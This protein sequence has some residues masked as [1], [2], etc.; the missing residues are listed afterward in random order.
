MANLLSTNVSGRLY[1]SGHNDTNTAMAAFRFYDGSTFRGGLGLDDWAHGG[2]AANI[3]M[4][5]NG[6]NNFFISTSGVKR[7]QFNSGAAIFRTYSP[8]TAYSIRIVGGDTIG[9]YYNESATTLYVNWNGGTTRFGTG[10]IRSAGDITADTNIWAANGNGRIA[11]GGNLHIDSYNGQDIYLNY[12]TNQPIR[13]YGATHVNGIAYLNGYTKISYDWGGGQYGAE[14]LTIRGTHPSIALR[15]TNANF[16]WLLHTDASGNF[17]WYTGSELDDN[18]WTNRFTF[19]IDNNFYVDY[20]HVYVSGG[21]SVNWN[22]AYGWGNHASAGYQSAST[23]I[24]TSNIGSQSVSY[25]S[26]ASD[27]KTLDG[28]GSSRFLYTTTD[29]F[30]GDWNTLTDG[31]QEIRLVEV[32]NITGGAHSN[33]PTGLYAYGSVLGWQLNNST[34]KLYNSHTGDLAFQTG[35]NNDGY[36]GWRTII[37]SANIG[38]QSVNYAASAGAVAWGNITSVPSSFTPSSHTHDDRYYT[39]SEVNT[40]LAGKL[41]TSGKAADAETVDGIDSSRIVYGQNERRTTRV[42]GDGIVSRSQ[43]SGFYYGYDPDGGPYREWWN[44]LTVAGASWTSNDNY[45]FKLAHDFHSDSFYVS[46]MANGAQYGWRQVI[47]SGNIGSQS[48]SNADTVDGYHAS[49]FPYRLNNSHYQTNN[50]IQFNAEYG[51]YWPNNYDTHLHANHLSSYTQLAIRG[52]KNSYGGIYDQYSGVNGFMYDS[53]GNGGVY[54][55]GTGRWYLYHHVGN[56]CM[57]VGTSTTSGSYRLYVAGGIYATGD[58]VA[59][60]DSRKKT[61]VVTIDNALNKVLSMRG[62]F[63]DKIGEPENGRQVGVIAQEVNEVLPEVV[64]YASDIDEYGVK[65]GNITAVLIEAIKEQQKQ[66]DEL[67]EIIN[68]LTK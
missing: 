24:T 68:G 23:A 48:V 10:G 56:N 33:Y 62:V 61:N 27:A 52:S 51:L 35:W 34:F 38:S 32:H 40:L 18:A 11:L 50:W 13:T 59:Y 17:R 31:D 26:T 39:E 25:A 37:H 64:N 19:G 2:S 55:E 1:V 22:T 8:D 7:A 67:K 36:S 9:A 66:I 57:G 3:T 58:V 20:G 16:K 30:S 63:Y 6:D 47:D 54:R 5:V 15:S 28:L 4:Y 41:S 43:N 53:S 12:Y 46:R 44:W 42:D 45:D 65:Y 21:N 14:Q 49:D 29:T 60:S